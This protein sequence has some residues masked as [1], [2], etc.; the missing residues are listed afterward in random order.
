M[1][2]GFGVVVMTKDND[3]IKNKDRCGDGSDYIVF[4][5]IN[6]DTKR[7]DEA[8]LN[9]NNPRYM[10]PGDVYWDMKTCRVLYD[11][12]INNVS[13]LSCSAQ[14]QESDQ[15]AKTLEKRAEANF[16]EIRYLMGE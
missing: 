9:C 13:D 5:K 8:F 4:Y 12:K 11:G 15:D 14:D 16:N 3:V 1:H 7:L 2:R 6:L 10:E